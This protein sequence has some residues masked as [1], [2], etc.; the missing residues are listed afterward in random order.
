LEEACKRST[1]EIAALN[2]RKCCFGR[3]D[4]SQVRRARINSDQT[5]LSVHDKLKVV[6]GA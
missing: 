3:A 2:A 4:D 5:A 6:G 1:A